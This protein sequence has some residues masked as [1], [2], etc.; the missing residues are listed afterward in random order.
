MPST[1]LPAYSQL[2]NQARELCNV[3]GPA[4]ALVDGEQVQ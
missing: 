1:V 3:T 4:E 2:Q